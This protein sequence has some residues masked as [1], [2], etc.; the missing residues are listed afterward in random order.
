MSFDTKI[1]QR[2]GTDPFVWF[3]GVVEDIEDPLQLGRV[4]VRILGDHTQ[5]VEKIPKDDLPWAYF[6]NDVHSASM[7]GI[8]NSPTGLYVKGTWVVGFYWDSLDKQQPVVTGTFGGI[9]ESISWHSGQ[10]G[11]QDPDEEF[12]IVSHIFE[13]DTNRLARNSPKDHAFEI[14]EDLV[15]KQEEMIED[16]LCPKKPVYGKKYYDKFDELFVRKFAQDESKKHS[17]DDTE[18]DVETDDDS[19]TDIKVEDKKDEKCQYFIETNDH[20]FTIY[21]FINRE[22]FIP[23]CKVFADPMHREV[24]HE[25]D[26]PWGTKYPFNRVWEGFHKE[27]TTEVKNPGEKG[28]GTFVTEAYGYNK[29]IEDYDGSKKEG[30]YRKQKCGIGSWGLGEEWDS[31]EGAQRYHRFHPS[32]NYFEI[33][34]DGNE[35]R[36]IYGDSFEIDLKDRTIL[37]KGD[38]NIT[39]EGDKNELIEGDYNLQVMKDFNT[40]VRGNIQ[41]HADEKGEYHYKGDHRIRVDGD[42]RIRV[43][44]DRDT[45]VLKK[46]YTESVDAE[47]RANTIIRKGAESIEDEGFKNF[48]IKAYDMLF[49]VCN[50][51]SQIMDWKSNVTTMTEDVVTKT[52]KFSTLTEDIGT[53]EQKKTIFNEEIQQHKE[54]VTV[55][56]GCIAEW[57]VECIDFEV[58]YQDTLLFQKMDV[59]NGEVFDCGFPMTP[60]PAMPTIFDEKAN[61]PET[62]GIQQCLKRY[63]E[64]IETAKGN[65]MTTLKDPQT[66]EDYTRFDWEKYHA[67]IDSC[68][69]SYEACVEA[70]K[71][72]ECDICSPAPGV[73]EWECMGCH[74]SDCPSDDKTWEFYE[75]SC[76]C[77]SPKTEEKID[78][79]EDC[80]QEKP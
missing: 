48:S 34:N 67:S 20:P 22:R 26:N 73:L 70:N 29:T 5:S 4:K 36:K 41:T 16:G 58:L 2:T 3:I 64:C 24:W 59:E 55:Y 7:Q 60:S 77:H 14:P 50:L 17:S 44:G 57:F 68:K 19:T 69:K 71:G 75:C 53:H 78:P 23:K 79:W 51:T 74:D 18:I 1:T 61:Y 6:I 76:P 62:D 72:M 11:F 33:D 40:D 63:N 12:P 8:G 9:P 43:S 32:A 37:I 65:C 10:V 27:G 66:L 49:E 15:P 54:T 25:P 52:N 45:S 35:M 42:D 46:D 31:T 38:W 13:Q 56:D 28:T 39:V 80:E 47:R 21:K 30:I